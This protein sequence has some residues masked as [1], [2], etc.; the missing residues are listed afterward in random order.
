MICT[1][2]QASVSQC[3]VWIIN[4]LIMTRVFR[5]GN[6]FGFWCRFWQLSASEGSACSWMDYGRYSRKSLEG[7][8]L[9]NSTGILT[10]VQ[11]NMGASVVPTLK[12]WGKTGLW[13]EEP[14]KGSPWVTR[15]TSHWPL[16][17]PIYFC[18]LG[19]KQSYE[20]NSLGHY[21][22]SLVR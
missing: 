15:V 3:D 2:C 16:C 21:L 11:E 8:P 18:S 10:H 1:M 12:L 9:I 14:R 13:G 4:A 7:E 20:S 19:K 22:S 6:L 5:A 17:L